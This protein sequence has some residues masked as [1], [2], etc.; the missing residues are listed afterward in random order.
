MFYK[1]EKD[2]HMVFWRKDAAALTMYVI[3]LLAMCRVDQLAMR[4]HKSNQVALLL[5][6]QKK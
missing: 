4:R 1:K 3:A 5:I 6:F 2:G